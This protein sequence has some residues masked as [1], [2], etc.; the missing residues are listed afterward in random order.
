MILKACPRCK[1]MIPQGLAYCAECLPK[2][3]ADRQ[4]AIDHRRELRRKKYNKAY[5]AQR[6]QVVTSFYRSKAWKAMSRSKLQDAKY[7][8]EAKLE[9]CKGLACEVHHKI[10]IKTPE[11][12]EHRFDWDGLQAVCTVCHNI[13]DGKTFKRRSDPNVIDLRDLIHKSGDNAT[14]R[15]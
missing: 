10:P 14:P 12:W 9:G 13:L 3:E 15:G 11:G 5:N 2:A 7:K 6:D 4:E 8:C 1:K